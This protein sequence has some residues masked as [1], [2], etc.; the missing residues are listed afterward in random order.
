MNS[1][2][3][4]I[5]RALGRRA[6]VWSAAARRRF[7]GGRPATL[8]VQHQASLNSAAGAFRE[9]RDRRQASEVRRQAPE[10]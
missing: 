8:N 9:T 7:V 3:F 2:R 1:K 4:A 10:E 6:S 5:D